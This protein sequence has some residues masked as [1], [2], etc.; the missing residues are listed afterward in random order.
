MSPAVKGGKP[1]GLSPAVAERIANYTPRKISPDVWTVI[2][3]FVRS[4]VTDFAAICVRAVDYSLPPTTR[5][6]AWCHNQGYPL[7]RAVVLDRHTIA[8]FVEDY[9]KVRT[10]RTRR[11][12]RSALMRIGRVL[13]PEAYPQPLPPIAKSPVAAPYTTAEQAALRS[14]ARGGRTTYRREQSALLLALGIGAGLTRADVE[15]LL[16]K[17]V[18]VDQDGVLIDIVGG[19]HPRMVPMLRDWEQAVVDVVNSGRDPDTY[20]VLPRAKSRSKNLTNTHKV[21]GAGAPSTIR[22]RATWMAAHLVNGVPIKAFLDASGIGNLESAE[23]ILSI[24]P[25]PD[26]VVARRALRG[27][28]GWT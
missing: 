14:W 8:L 3:P 17:H 13:V 19:R 12:I 21:Y 22:M 5:L 15:H 11:N 1:S 26:P 7:E 6:V 16:V 25:D 28:A 18:T 4:T 24:L 10:L 2:A 9:Y 27:E 23:R 20:L